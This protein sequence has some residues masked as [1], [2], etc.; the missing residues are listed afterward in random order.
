[1]AVEPTD[2]ELLAFVQALLSDLGEELRKPAVLS[3]AI[4]Q[5]RQHWVTLYRANLDLDDAKEPSG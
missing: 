1:V 3:E 2:E 5:N 4:A